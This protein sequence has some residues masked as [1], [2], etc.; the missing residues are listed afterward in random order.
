MI[1]VMTRHLVLHGGKQSAYCHT[2][3]AKIIVAEHSPINWHTFPAN[4]IYWDITD[5]LP[6]NLWPIDYSWFVIYE[7]T[8]T[9]IFTRW[10]A[11]LKDRKAANAIAA[12]LVR[13]SM[14]NLGDIEPVGDGISDMRIFTGKGYRV[15]F[16]IRDGELILLINGGHKGT[17]QKDILKAKEILN[18]LEE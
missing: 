8:A 10:Q 4:G 2:Q 5:N 17:Q 9:E 13:A 11:K 7:I 18:H 3:P 12:R 1:Y 6:C 14:G 16:T 15:Y